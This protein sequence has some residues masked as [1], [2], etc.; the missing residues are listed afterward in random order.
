MLPGAYAA[1]SRYAVS[2]TNTT[3]DE[4][5]IVLFAVV[6]PLDVVSITS[7]LVASAIRG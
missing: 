5:S 6:M 4:V 2:V 7:G 3:R 1:N